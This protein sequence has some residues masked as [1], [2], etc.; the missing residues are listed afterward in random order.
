MPQLNAQKCEY[1]ANTL[2]KE[3]TISTAFPPTLL[4]RMVSTTLGIR[5]RWAMHASG[6][7]KGTTDARWCEL[8]TFLTLLRI[9]AT[10]ILASCVR[11]AALQ[12]SIVHALRSCAFVWP[13][14]PHSHGTFARKEL[15]E[16]SAKKITAPDRSRNEVKK[17]KRQHEMRDV[18]GGP[19][20]IGM[21]P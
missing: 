12:C 18:P 16:R 15:E 21:G 20:L 5:M 14:H 3:Q 17:E 4:G 6:K 11:H 1:R 8:L 9:L 7:K 13:W 19:S 2:N 10:E